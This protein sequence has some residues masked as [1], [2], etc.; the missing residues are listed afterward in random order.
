MIRSDQ[1]REDLLEYAE[2]L[3]RDTQS[4]S[5]AESETKNDTEMKKETKKEKLQKNRPQS[6]PKKEPKSKKKQTKI[7]NYIKPSKK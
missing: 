3:A 1:E 2:T 4:T 6:P 7:L 5:L